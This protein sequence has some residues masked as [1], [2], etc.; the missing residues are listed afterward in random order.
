MLTVC[1]KF[2]RQVIIAQLQPKDAKITGNIATVIFLIF[3]TVINQNFVTK[4][5]QNST[6]AITVGKYIYIGHVSCIISAL[7]ATQ[8]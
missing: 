7:M 6:N 5:K 1:N 2:N 4:I 3:G 8:F